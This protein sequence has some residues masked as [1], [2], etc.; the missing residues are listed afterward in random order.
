MLRLAERV[1]IVSAAAAAWAGL[2]TQLYILATGPLGF[3]GGLW[4]FLR[5]F[6]IWSNILVAFVATTLLFKPNLIS[7]SLRAGTAVFISIVGVIYIALLRSLWKP[8]GL[9]LTAD[10]LLHYASPTFFVLHWIAFSPKSHLRWRDAL[11]WLA[12]PLVYFVYALIRGGLEGVYPYPFIDVGALGPN[13]VAFNAALLMLFFFIL[14]C[15]F[16]AL[17]KFSRRVDVHG[18]ST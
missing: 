18:P 5:F 8:E 2:S 9:Q 14:G 12:F 11:R 3:G 1:L 6:T 7:E 13:R 15:I 4:A 16:V 17:G 10:I